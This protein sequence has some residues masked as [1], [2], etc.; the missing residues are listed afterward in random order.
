MKLS[1]ERAKSSAQYVILRGINARRIAGKGFGESQLTNKCGNGVKCTEDEHRQNR[2]TEFII[3]KMKAEKA[4]IGIGCMNINIRP[5]F[6]SRSEVDN[7]VRG[8][9]LLRINIINYYLFLFM[10][11]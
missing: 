5:L 7:I 11:V 8:N 10:T 1:D 9:I 6:V 2:R 4:H 3:V